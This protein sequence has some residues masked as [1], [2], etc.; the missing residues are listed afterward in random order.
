MSLVNTQNLVS[1]SEQLV[2]FPDTFYN[3]REVVEYPNCDFDDI[4][5]VISTNPS[6]TFRFLKKVN[7]AF[8]SLSGEMNTVFMPWR[9][10]EQNN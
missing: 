4:A 7:S 5:E 1:K 2:S 10:L 3:L 6:L 8:Y 9:L